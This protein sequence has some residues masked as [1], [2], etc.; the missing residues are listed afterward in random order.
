MYL[1]NYCGKLYG[2]AHKYTYRD[3]LSYF[4]SQF[5]SELFSSTC[6]QVVKEMIDTDLKS[7][8]LPQ[9]NVAQETMAR[10]SRTQ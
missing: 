4:L 5:F 8:E 2:Y 6:N 3:K 1:R 7:R 10:L 9:I